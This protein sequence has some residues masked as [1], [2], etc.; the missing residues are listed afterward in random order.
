MLSTRTRSA[1]TAETWITGNAGLL[2]RHD[3]VRRA[4]S[5]IRGIRTIVA[6]VAVLSGCA[7]GGG[8]SAV[9]RADLHGDWVFNRDQS[10]SLD[11][12]ASGGSRDGG[13]QRGGGIDVMDGTAGSRG[14]GRGGRGIGGGFGGGGDSF[15]PAQLR[16]VVRSLASA[17]NRLSVEQSDTAV[18][19]QYSD[20]LPLPLLTNCKDTKRTL[21]GL[22]EAEIK[23]EW[24][25]GLLIVEQKL[26][27]GIKLR[28]EYARGPASRRLVVLTTVTG[29]GPRAVTVRTVYDLEMQDASVH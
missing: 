1:V 8:G 19:L 11:S 4:S 17:R 7:S 27:G 6:A 21:P 25:D 2:G 29:V 28:S 24:K 3:G 15:D 5:P 16:A 14:G 9:T 26:D 23:A 20:N 12:L 10:Q 22:G 13:G 18:S